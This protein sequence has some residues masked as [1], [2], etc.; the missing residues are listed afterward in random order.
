[1]HHRRSDPNKTATDEYYTPTKVW[2]DIKQHISSDKVI[3]EPFFG[4]GHTFNYFKENGYNII[5]KKD[6]DF[7]SVDG[8]SM[9]KKCDCVISNPPYSKKY[10]IIKK[11]VENDVPFILTMPL[12][13]INT[14][15][16]LNAF[17][18]NMDNVSIII[19]K[20][21]MKYIHNGSIA[22]SPSFESCYVCY[23]MIKQKL[24]FLCV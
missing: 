3:F 7:F 21:R 4:Q 24:I 2:D 15:V 10:K 9:L 13:A 8:T 16:F 23:K 1:M 11:L 5:G 12:S 22:N 18:N 17:N 20:G 6:L 19:P 14:I